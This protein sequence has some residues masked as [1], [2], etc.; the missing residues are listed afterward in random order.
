M[1]L[2]FT[3]FISGS[4]LPAES[5]PIPTVS[6]HSPDKK[7]SNNIKSAPSSTSNNTISSISQKPISN[8]AQTESDSSPEQSHKAHVSF[9]GWI[10]KVIYDPVS[11]FT[12]VLALSTVGL[13]IY[14]IVSG[15]NQSKTMRSVA[16]SIARSASAAE[17]GVGITRKISARQRKFAKTQ[18][19]AYVFIDSISVSNIANPA[20]N[21]VIPGNNP[22]GLQYPVHGPI[23]HMSIK[24]FGNTPAHDVV[25]WARICIREFPLNP[26]HP[27]DGP[28]DGN[29]TKMPLIPGSPSSKWVR[30]PHP[31]TN[32]EIASLRVNTSA[33]YVYGGITY[34]DEFGDERWTKFCFFHNELT[35]GVGVTTDMTGYETGNECN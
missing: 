21:I 24:N 30:F 28:P 33:I 31:L 34:K 9:A 20:P 23:T 22:A 4:V 26:L 12:F 15:T 35:G 11:L 29:P 16:E 14:S 3:S 2:L 10:E 13:W 6:N 8:S 27:L 17:T 25:H 19:R 32:D 5:Q 18:L 7:E 1:A